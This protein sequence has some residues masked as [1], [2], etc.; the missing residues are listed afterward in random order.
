MYI[1]I[2]I[3]TYIHTYI[4]NVRTK[5]RNVCIY[6][7][8]SVNRCGCGMCWKCWLACI[9]KCVFLSIKIHIYAY[10]STC[11]YEYIF[12]YIYMYMHT[13]ARFREARQDYLAGSWPQQQRELWRRKERRPRKEEGRK[14]EGRCQVSCLLQRGRP[15]LYAGVHVSMSRLRRPSAYEHIVFL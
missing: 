15:R 13:Q 9:C 6:V 7:N 14:Q 1:Y 5:G 8:S 3:Y 10:I 2:Y 11:T 12:I 4:C